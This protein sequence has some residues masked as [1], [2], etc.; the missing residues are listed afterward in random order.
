MS[1]A[2]NFQK[3]TFVYPI[4]PNEHAPRAFMEVFTETEEDYSREVFMFR[5]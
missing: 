4:F 5:F 1:L 3:F 2:N